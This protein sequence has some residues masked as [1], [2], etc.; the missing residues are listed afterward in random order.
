MPNK[1]QAK[2]ALDAVVVL[3]KA[4]IDTILPA[5]PVPNITQGNVSISPDGWVITCTAADVTAAAAMKD[6][7]TTNLTTAVRSYTVAFHRRSVDKPRNIT[8]TSGDSRFR[9]LF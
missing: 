8:V 9:I 6:A 3:I 4:D 5:S 7:I 1:T 2:A